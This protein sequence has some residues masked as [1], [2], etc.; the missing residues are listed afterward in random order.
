LR[1][2]LWDKEGAEDYRENYG[3]RG[4]GLARMGIHHDGTTGTRRQGVSGAGFEF[5]KSESRRAGTALCA[6]I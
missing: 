6:T 2:G 5:S 4:G 1:F 3:R